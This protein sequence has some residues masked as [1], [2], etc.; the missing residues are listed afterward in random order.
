MANLGLIRPTDDEF[1]A[2]LKPLKI[3]N[4]AER[5]DKV[6]AVQFENNGVP[7]VSQGVIKNVEVM[8][9]PGARR[10]LLSYEASIDLELGNT[11]ITP[12]FRRGRLVGLMVGYDKSGR[13]AMLIPSPVIQHFLD[14]LEDGMYDGFPRA[15]FTTSAI[16]DPQLRR[17]LG[18]ENGEPGVYVTQ[19]IP[20]TPAAKAGMLEGDVLLEIAGQVI[21]RHG[22]YEDKDYGPLAMSHLIS[23]MC[24]AGDK[25]ACLIQ[26]GEEELALEMTM[27]RMDVEEFPVPPYVIDRAPRFLIEDGFVF[28]ELSV[29]F[30]SMWGDWVTKAPRQL[31]RLEREQWD[32]LKPGER[33]VILAR[34]L[35][36][37]DNIGYQNIRFE[38]VDTVNGQEVKSV[39][40]VAAAFKEAGPVQYHTVKLREASAPEIVIKAATL[41]L[42][43]RFVSERYGI[44]HL[45]NLD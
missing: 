22:Q 2:Q 30:L 16:Q 25:V 28:Q 1:A 13:T 37:P 44:S 17:Y 27:D 40:D 33:V 31:T 14:D 8:T 5:G 15:G 6:T 7:S 10:Q 26:R 45:S 23:T 9:P 35:P 43:N 42:A 39:R 36:T 19:V 29:Q 24:Q 18:I 20:G 21:D 34:V 38:I 41:E 12:F 3:R 32:K 4:M 11:G